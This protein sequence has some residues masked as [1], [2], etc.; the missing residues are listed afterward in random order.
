MNFI[1]RSITIPFYNTPTF[2]PMNK[3]ITI[4]VFALLMC[5][6]RAADCQISQ[7]INSVHIAASAINQLVL[8]LGHGEVEIRKTMGSRILIETTI[9]VALPNDRLLTFL[10]EQ[11]RY[12]LTSHTDNSNGVLRINNRKNNNILIVKGREC[13]ELVSHIVYVPNQIQF[14]NNQLGENLY[15]AESKALT[16]NK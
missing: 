6:V 2:F 4:L 5:C 11:G 16:F 1:E 3:F 8:D 14:V 12:E 10:V 15:A 7:T 13:E 9:K